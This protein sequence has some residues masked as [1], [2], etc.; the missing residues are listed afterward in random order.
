MPNYVL[1]ITAQIKG[2]WKPVVFGD[3]MSDKIDK[4]LK[5]GFVQER[6]N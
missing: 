2:G 3:K 4:K 1:E 5:Y 6:I